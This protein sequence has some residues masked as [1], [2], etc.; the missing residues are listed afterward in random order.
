MLIGVWES[1]VRILKKNRKLFGV[2]EMTYALWGW[3]SATFAK[4][5]FSASSLTFIFSV[6]LFIYLRNTI[7]GVIAVVF[8]VGVKTSG[9]CVL[10]PQEFNSFAKIIFSD[11]VLLQLAHQVLVL[12]PF[13]K[14]VDRVVLSVI[15]NEVDGIPHVLQIVAHNEPMALIRKLL[16]FEIK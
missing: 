6:A 5:S 13:R 8:G 15:L 9:D 4:I 2:S 12:H 7:V 3:R 16:L 1:I 10:D 11:F 14:G